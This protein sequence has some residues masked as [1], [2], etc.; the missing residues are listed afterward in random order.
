MQ[1]DKIILLQ[2]VTFHF[3]RRFWHISYHKVRRNNCVT[4]CGR[5][6]LQGVSGITKCD[7]LYYKVR[8]VLQSVT[9]S[10]K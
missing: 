6:L 1:I 7:I 3:L 8:Q 10:T 9:V 2:S 5:L 4:K